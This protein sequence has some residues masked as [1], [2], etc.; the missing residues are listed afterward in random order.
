[1]LVSINC[2]KSKLFQGRVTIFSIFFCACFLSS[3][4]FADKPVNVKFPHVVA[5]D[6]PK[7]K[8]AEFLK[9]TLEEKSGG[10]IKVAVYPNS[11]LY[12]DGEAIG[13]LLMGSVQI[14]CP[15]TSKL[16]TVVPEF[17]VIDIPFLFPT[18]G[19]VHRSFDGGLGKRLNALLEKKGL[20]ALAYW[21]N[22]YK[23]LGNSRRPVRLPGDV[24]GLKFRIMSSKVLE[25][26]F[27]Q[28]GANPQV[29]AF[30]EVYTALEQGVIDGQEN[31]WSNMYSQK[32][33]EAQK[34]ITETNHG[35]LGYVLLTSK[36]FWDSLSPDLQKTFSEAVKTATA[37]ERKIARE[38]NEKQKQKIIGLG[39]TQITTLTGAERTEWIN[40]FAPLLRK[41]PKWRELIELARNP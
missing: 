22:G 18:L 6:T 31:S 30:S 39:K 32:F 28:V 23:Q 24:K 40:A 3:P 37:Y 16:T 13:A 15:S 29:M 4:A 38:I 2:L 12:R 8:A 14:I 21:D 11:Q 7:G 25:N 41:Y 10:R 1:M 35:Y 26:Q 36:M 5:V 9:K 17:Q 20:K 27:E 19:D 34:Y 33:H